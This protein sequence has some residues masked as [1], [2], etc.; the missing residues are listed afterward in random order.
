MSICLSYVLRN[1]LVDSI[2]LFCNTSDEAD[3]AFIE[4]CAQNLENVRLI[5][6][7]K[8]VTPDGSFTVRHLYEATTDPETVYIKCDDDIVYF[9]DDAIENLL[10]ARFAFSQAPFVSANVVNNPL[11]YAEQRA[12]GTAP[13]LPA[14]KG[15]VVNVHRH[16]YHGQAVHEA[17]LNRMQTEASTHWVRFPSKD[18]PIQRWSINFI[19]YF[20]HLVSQ[21]G[22]AVRPMA[23]GKYDDE[24]YISR[25]IEDRHGTNVL[26]GDAVVSHYAFFRQLGHMETTNILKRYEHIF[27]DRYSDD[28]HAAVLLDQ[29]AAI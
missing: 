16:G 23:N 17:F 20:G 10:A 11:C 24:E 8:G 27:L 19:A 15:G 14:G 21:Q 25:M 26:C 7:P 28:P 13:D 22:F 4:W 5:H 9:D 2:A 3:L 12:R 6:L 18:I 1:P 29:A